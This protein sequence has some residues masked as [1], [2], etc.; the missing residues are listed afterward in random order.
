MQQVFLAI[1][2]AIF[3]FYHTN[4]SCFFSWEVKNGNVHKFGAVRKS[5]AADG[6]LLLLLLLLS[7]TDEAFSCGTQP[8]GCW[9]ENEILDRNFVGWIWGHVLAQ[10]RRRRFNVQ[11]WNCTTHTVTETQCFLA[12]HSGLVQHHR[13]SSSLSSPFLFKNP[14]V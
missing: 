11:V 7:E 2:G 6:S 9:W 8:A 5:D 1:G 10:Q 3:F 13:L 4:W 14:L 12:F